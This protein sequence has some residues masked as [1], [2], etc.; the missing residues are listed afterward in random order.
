MPGQRLTADSLVRM[1]RRSSLPPPPPPEHIRA[2][3]DR[4]ALLADRAA[5][6]ADLVRRRVGV[7]RLLLFLLVLAVLQLGW[8][9]LGAGLVSMGPTLDV[10][11]VP[12]LMVC[13][14]LSVAVIVPTVIG[15]A[16]DLG[17]DRR[18][19]VL[20]AQWAALDTDPV[21]DARLRRP[22]CSLSW[23]L[24]CFALGALGLWI[25]F[26][27]PAEAR[28]GSSTYGRV[29]YFMGVGFICWVMALIGA[30]RAVSHYRW[31]IRLVSAVPDGASRGRP[32]APAGAAAVPGAAVGDDPA[33]QVPASGDGEHG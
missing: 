19:R 10:V 16:L 4:E 20:L 32:G 31:A 1:S 26:A 28:P 5:V 33:A 30:T 13:A 22:G 14:V 8:G 12:M 27:V 9:F 3:P 25:C 18:L 29:A 23:L 21:R 6:L 15:V 11:S 2:W 17:R 7:P 24:V